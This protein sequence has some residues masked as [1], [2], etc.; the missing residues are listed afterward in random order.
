MGAHDPSMQES[1]GEDGKV[2]VDGGLSDERPPH[3]R[4]WR[5]L[6]LSAWEIARKVISI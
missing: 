4:R 3:V 6:H 1:R 2:D 5:D